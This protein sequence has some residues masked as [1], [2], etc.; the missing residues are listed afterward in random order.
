MTDG[1]LIPKRLMKKLTSIRD[2]NF[3]PSKL[4][5]GIDRE[6]LHQLYKYCIDRDD[7]DF[8]FI[9]VNAPF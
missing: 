8:L 9:D 4:N 2:L 5:L 7:K 3:I 1:F 6:T